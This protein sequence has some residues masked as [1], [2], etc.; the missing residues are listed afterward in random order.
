[1]ELGAAPRNFQET[2]DKKIL[3][4]NSKKLVFYLVVRH[5]GKVRT[6]CTPIKAT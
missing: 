6:L 2:L 1:M 4:H 3:I 5:W